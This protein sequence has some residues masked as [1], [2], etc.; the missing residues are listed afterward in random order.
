MTNP[1]DNGF[2]P[3]PFPYYF[4]GVIIG[5]QLSHIISQKDS[6]QKI[7]MSGVVVRVRVGSGGR[8]LLGILQYR[9][10]TGK[11]CQQ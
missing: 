1:I 9:V 5:Y 11:V 3:F 7:C 6:V 2:P 4:G 10:T 8:R